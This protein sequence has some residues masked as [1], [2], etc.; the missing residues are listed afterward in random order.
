MNPRKWIL[1]AVTLAMIAGTALALVRVGR[2]HELGRPG[3]RMIEQPVLDDRGAVIGNFTV[4]L[5][6]R[7][8]DYDS[9][10]MPIT[11]V[12]L[13]WLPKDTTYA[14]RHYHAPDRF[15]LMLNVVMMGTD[16]TSIHKPEICLTGQGW[17][18]DRPQSELITVPIDAPHRY[19]LPVM[20]IT[21]TKIMRLPDG[22]EQTWRSLYLYWFVAEDRVTA[23]HNER[24]WWMAQG[25]LRTGTLQRWA[26]VSCMAFCPPGAEDATLIRLKEFIR[27]A[28]PD[29]QLPTGAPATR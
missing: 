1:L 2:N 13:S 16:R 15:E 10:T 14:R 9:K 21:A 17:S 6:E 24:M 28:V 26:Y 5:P 25:L 27:A 19:E 22:R 12:E 18:I 7:V 29:F 8:L 4:D 20:K 3:L 23:S 11:Q